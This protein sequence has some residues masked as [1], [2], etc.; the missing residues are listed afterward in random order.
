MFVNNFKNIDVQSLA[1]LRDLNFI[2]KDFDDLERILRFLQVSLSKYRLKRLTLYV[3]G[4]NS[5]Y[6]PFDKSDSEIILQRNLL[7]KQIII[8]DLNSFF[9][10]REF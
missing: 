5:Y 10:E 2:A 1:Q 4:F 9:Y 3:T 7:P 8:H 6:D